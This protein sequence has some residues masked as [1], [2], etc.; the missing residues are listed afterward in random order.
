MIILDSSGSVGPL[1]F[2]NMKQFV[3]RL[4]R[5]ATIDEGGTRI[6]LTIYSSNAQVMWHLNA[7]STRDDMAAALVDRVRMSLLGTVQ[8]QPTVAQEPVDLYHGY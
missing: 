2:D 5:E 1:N 8:R 3:L 6:G 4:I 7:F